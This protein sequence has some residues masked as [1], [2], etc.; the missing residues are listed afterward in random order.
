ML[1]LYFGRLDWDGEARAAQ[2]R[3][4]KKGAGEGPAGGGGEALGL[5]E[6]ADEE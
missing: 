6:A 4:A 1:A 5:L 3:S 2:L